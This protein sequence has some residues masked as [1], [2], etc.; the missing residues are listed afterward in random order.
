MG[1]ASFLPEPP[2]VLPLGPECG[3]NCLTVTLYFSICC[4][5]LG[6]GRGVQAADVVSIYPPKKTAVQRRVQKANIIQSA[7]NGIAGYQTCL[8]K[9]DIS[10]GT[11]VKMGMGNRRAKK[12]CV[13]YSTGIKLGTLNTCAVKGCLPDST[14]GKVT[15]AEIG[16][17]QIRMV[18]YTVKCHLVKVGFPEEAGRKAFLCRLVIELLI[19]DF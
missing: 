19:D 18:G 5:A 7:V 3:K 2:A 4:S 6:N 14:H 12:G 9:R 17:V 8:L 13:L 16:E 10:Q 1:F 15:V 11:V